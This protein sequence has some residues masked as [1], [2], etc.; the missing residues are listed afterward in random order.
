MR[1]L[2]AVIVALLCALA[3]FALLAMAVFLPAL[4]VP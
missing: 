3:V 4:L 1:N 2:H